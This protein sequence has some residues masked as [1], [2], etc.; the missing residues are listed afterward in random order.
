MWI[1]SEVAEGMRHET[2][3]RAADSCSNSFCSLTLR[4]H[5]LACFTA[6]RSPLYTLYTCH[7]A[8]FSGL[9]AFLLILTSFCC[10]A[11][12][13]VE[14]GHPRFSSFLAGGLSFSYLLFISSKEQKTKN[15]KEK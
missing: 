15:E 13:T 5:L 8:G 14:F 1:K 2:P 12:S 3:L 6:V 4:L 7:P 11:N 9:L 10:F